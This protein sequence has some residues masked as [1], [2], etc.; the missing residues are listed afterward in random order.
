MLQI[1]VGSSLMLQDPGPT[2]QVGP[3]PDP[4]F[5]SPIFVLLES[6]IFGFKKLI[7][8]LLLYNIWTNRVGRL[9]EENTQAPSLQICKSIIKKLL[10]F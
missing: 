4:S 8:R 1:Y 3:L 9:E 7:D 6:Y 5:S 2:F 10:L